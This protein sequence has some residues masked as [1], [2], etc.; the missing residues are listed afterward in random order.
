MVTA[1]FAKPNLRYNSFEDIDIHNKG[2]KIIE[3]G[4]E[5]QQNM[6]QVTNNTNKDNIINSREGI[7]KEVFENVFQKYKDEYSADSYLKIISEE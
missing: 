4:Y 6:K 2:L 1:T 5:D 3:W 7:E